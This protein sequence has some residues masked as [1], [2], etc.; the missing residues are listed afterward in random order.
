MPLGLLVTL[1]LMDGRLGL[2]ALRLVLLV[3]LLL[4][5]CCCKRRPRDHFE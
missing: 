4:L 5:L 1:A 3:W 2:W